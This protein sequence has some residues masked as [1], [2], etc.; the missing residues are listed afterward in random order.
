MISLGW[1]LF[2]KYRMVHVLCR[3]KMRKLFLNDS[4]VCFRMVDV[5]SIKLS[6]NGAEY[7]SCLIQLPGVRTPLVKI[8]DPSNLRSFNADVRRDGGRT[9]C[10]NNVFMNVPRLWGLILNMQA[11]RNLKELKLLVAKFA[12]LDELVVRLFLYA[13]LSPAYNAFCTGQL[14]DFEV[15]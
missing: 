12:I 4:K 14:P 3:S 6:A 9:S 5:R 2:W 11:N 7:Y 8:S 10:Q 1:R 13:E 15:D